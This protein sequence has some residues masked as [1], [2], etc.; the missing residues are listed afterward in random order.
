MM[1]RD[2]LLTLAVPVLLTYC[3]CS[4]DRTLEEASVAESQVLDVNV[5]RA[6]RSPIKSTLELVG[7]LIPIRATT[8]VSDVDGIIKSFPLSDRKIEFED[9]GQRQSVTLGL[10]IGH[11]VKQ[12]D[13]LVQIDPID[14]ELNLGVTKAQLDLAKSE[15]ANLMAWK[16]AEEVDQLRFLVEESQATS[17]RAESDLQRSRKLLERR[18]TSQSDHDAMVMASQTAAAALHRTEAAFK[19]AEA[20][21]TK[22]QIDVAKARIAA[23]E[24]QVKCQAEK[25]AKTTI[26]APYDAVISERYVDVG[27]RVTAM[28]RVEILQI[29]DPRVLLAQ[30][31][32]PEDYQGLV[33]LD[34]VAAVQ[35]PGI[36]RAVAGVV[37]LVNEMIDLQTR[38]FR[39]RIAIDNRKRVFKAGGFVNVTLPV[40]SAVDVLAVP[41]G[42]VTFTEGQP[43]V[44]ICRDDC[45]RKRPVR[46]GISS[47]SHYEIVEGLEEG[48]L[49]VVGNTSLLA[50]GL[51][52]RPKMTTPL[53][54]TR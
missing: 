13:V 3:G 32:V 20:G 41:A 6:S 12:G 19:L 45:V 11:R 27:D 25:L 26:R 35:A 15:L 52:V 9:G 1:K 16:R 51:K 39:I 31:S 42:A 14:F 10:D 5:V 54:S 29:I 48:E 40:A 30:V 23:A 24:A 44:F 2:W 46:L 43:A 8:I 7:T 17:K 37:D 36:T 38:T 4:G 18:V 28:P 22:E 33:K 47:Q 34:D 49:V 21:P 50:D 53:A